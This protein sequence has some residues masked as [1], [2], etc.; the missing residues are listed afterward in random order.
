M[1][2]ILAAAATL[3]FLAG[4]QAAFGQVKV[5][6]ESKVKET[7]PGP[8]VKVKSVTTVGTVKEY[9]AGRKIKIIG[10]QDKTY[11]FDLD[12]DARVIGRIAP[13]ETATVTWKKDSNGKEHVSVI[14][15]SGSVLGAAEIA[16]KQPQP[17]E[18]NAMRMKSKTT[19]H[20]PGPN[21]RTKT[22]VVVGTVKEF[23][24]GKKIKVTG[25]DDKD[26][27]FD[28]DQGVGMNGKVVVG[29]RVRVEYTK[30]NDGVEHVTVV[31]LVPG[32]A[33]KAT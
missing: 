12:H 14:K 9:E 18:G 15:G 20:Q 28:L 8:D 11:S 17:A 30:S 7:G 6:T 27:A 16:A 31:S 22:E 3:C 1:K 4:A 21:T 10:P 23:E 26:Y 24:P 2:K 25:P 5:H 32:K 13:G 33:R 29:S 19:V